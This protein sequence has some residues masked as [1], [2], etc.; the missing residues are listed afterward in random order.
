M[1]ER[2]TLYRGNFAL[3]EEVGNSDCVDVKGAASLEEQLI[4][5]PNL[6]L[7]ANWNNQ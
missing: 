3:P 1:A 6:K 5:T 2:E 7:V 4:K